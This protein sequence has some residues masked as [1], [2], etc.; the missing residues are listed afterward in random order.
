MVFKQKCIAAFIYVGVLLAWMSIFDPV[1]VYDMFEVP[2]MSKILPYFVTVSVVGG[3]E[4]T[5]CCEPYV[6]TGD[7]YSKSIESI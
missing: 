3:H 6:N 4:E 7:L 2:E 1:Q 5:Q